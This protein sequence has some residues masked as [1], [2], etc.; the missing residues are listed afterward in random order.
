[1]G[2]H[3]LVPMSLDIVSSVCRLMYWC[4]ECTSA[5]RTETSFYVPSTATMQ[6]LADHPDETVLNLFNRFVAT[7]EVDEEDTTPASIRYICTFLVDVA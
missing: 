7:P 4:I 1:M 5:L 6:F 2:T 3:W